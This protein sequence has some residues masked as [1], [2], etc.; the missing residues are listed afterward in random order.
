M[1]IAPQRASELVANGGAWIADV[2]E[3]D[4]YRQQHI[5]G[6]V[7]CPTSLMGVQD[8]PAART[9]QEMLVLCRSGTRAGRVAQ[10]LR[11]QGRTDVQVIQGGITAWAKDGL[12]VVTN[13]RAPL[14]II[15]QVMI[16]VGT[17]VLAFVALGAL[18]HP[19][20]LLG[21]GAMGAGLLFAGATGICA[22]A[23]LLGRAPW[24]KTPL[25]KQCHQCHNN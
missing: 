5:A 10:S 18:V 25:V 12:P 2:R 20:W 4:E 3:P 22:M 19:L 15:R 8:Y 23:S 9:G 13:V 17:M 6:S 11:A 14:P 24:N 7:L 16:T 21:A 1:A